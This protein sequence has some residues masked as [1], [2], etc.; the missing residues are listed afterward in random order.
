MKLLTLNKFELLEMGNIYSYFVVTT[1]FNFSPI[2]SKV[3]M[4]YE[5]ITFSKNLL[6]ILGYSQ[7]EFVKVV[8]TS[9]FFE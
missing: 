7:D 5:S 4:G 1:R 8:R 9:G 3:V 2:N 6:Q